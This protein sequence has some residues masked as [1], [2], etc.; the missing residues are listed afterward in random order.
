MRQA[1]VLPRNLSWNLCIDA[2][3]ELGAWIVR[4][5]HM[6]VKGITRSGWR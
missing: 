5:E 6:P 3:D 2:D 4:L 1:G